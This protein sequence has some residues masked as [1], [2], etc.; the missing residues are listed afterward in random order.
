MDCTE[1]KEK[2]RLLLIESKVGNLPTVENL[3][4][5]GACLDSA[6]Q[7]TGQ[8]ALMLAAKNGRLDVVQY[9]LPGPELRLHFLV[10]F[11]VRTLYARVRL[12]I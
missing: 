11:T 9:L 10:A 5:A 2:N 12:L 4:N 8:T 3:I 6:D 1:D 7:T